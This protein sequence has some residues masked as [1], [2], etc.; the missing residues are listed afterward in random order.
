MYSILFWY[1]FLP[2][3]HEHDVKLN[4]PHAHETH[5]HSI[6]TLQHLTN[7]QSNCKYYVVNRFKLIEVKESGYRRVNY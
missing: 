5:L 1:I 3:L 4:K 2:S 6:K 7:G